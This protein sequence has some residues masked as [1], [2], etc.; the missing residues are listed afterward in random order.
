MTLSSQT[1]EDPAELAAELSRTVVRAKI[2]VSV[3]ESLT[4]G[5]LAIRLGAAESSGEWFA[6]G[7]V[8]YANEVKYRVLG[9][10][11]GPVITASCAQ[12]M[13]QGVAALTGSDLAVAT[14]GVGGPGTAEGKAVGTVF[15]AVH[16]PS[17]DQIEE[18]HFPGECEDVLRAT[19][20]QALRMLLT[21][22]EQADPR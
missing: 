20:V 18:F 12:Q 7:V 11:L 9:V 22:A 16:S 10:D 17:G 19:T 21:A 15:I 14:T 5:Q 1:F 2:T 13:A 8:A 6:G 3:A 4:S